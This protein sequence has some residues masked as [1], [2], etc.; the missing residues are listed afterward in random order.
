MGYDNAYIVNQYYLNNETKSLKRV[1]PIVTL[2]E[3]KRIFTIQ[4]KASKSPLNIEQFS[5]IKDVREIL[6]DDGYY[7]YV[8]GDY[9]ELSKA[10]EAVIPIHEAGFK[11]AFI[12]ELNILVTKE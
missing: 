4:L 11:D 3:G 6:G 12:R 5:A 10:Q 8:V 1:A 7:R 2:T 9:S